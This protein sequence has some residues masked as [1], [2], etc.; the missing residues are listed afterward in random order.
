MTERA[1]AL[2]GLDEAWDKGEV[3]WNQS[4]PTDVVR[5]VS[6]LLGLAWPIARDPTRLGLTSTSAGKVHR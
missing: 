5:I 1:D 6:G 3:P 4:D 2:P